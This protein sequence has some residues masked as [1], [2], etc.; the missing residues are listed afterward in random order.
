MILSYLIIDDDEVF[1]ETLAYRLRRRG[2][3]ARTATDATAAMA[4]CARRCPQRIILDLKLAET[5]GLRLLPELRAQ[6]PD[7]EIVILTGYA[8]IATAVSAI[9]LGAV[10][11]LAKPA[12]LDEILAAFD[13]DT[14]L[15]A[16]APETLPSLNRVEWEYIQRALDEHEGNIA[17]TARALGMH[18]RTLQRKLAKRPT[19]R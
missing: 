8:S 17:A 11:Y 10:H 3:E 1:A 2:Q 7:A 13:A 12:S 4:I 9:K 5:S 16:P 18:R 15:P 19:R 14:P 6:L